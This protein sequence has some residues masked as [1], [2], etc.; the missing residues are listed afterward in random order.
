MFVVGNVGS[1]V[2]QQLIYYR[3]ALIV[4]RICS[5]FYRKTIDQLVSLTGPP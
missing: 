1:Q 4:A 5:S 3:A 2:T